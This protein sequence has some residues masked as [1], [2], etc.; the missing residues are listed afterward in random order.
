MGKYIP[1]IPLQDEKMMGMSRSAHL[2]TG[3]GAVGLSK[4]FFTGLTG[5]SSLGSLLVLAQPKCARSPKD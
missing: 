1:S 4:T 5:G 2:N 3:G